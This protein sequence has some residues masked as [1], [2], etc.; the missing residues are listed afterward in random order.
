MALLLV[1]PLLAGWRGQYTVDDGY[2][3][4][5]G[6]SARARCIVHYESRFDPN[7]VGQAGEVGLAQLHP[8]GKLP[9]FYALGYS[10]P[11]NPYQQAE[12]LEWALAQ[13]QAFH[14]SPVLRGLC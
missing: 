1:L 3:A 5:E 2:A 9:E 4:M 10:D 11:W 13:G 7:A 14:W 6:R 12:Y 8:Y